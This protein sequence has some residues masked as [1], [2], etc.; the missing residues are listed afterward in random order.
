MHGPCS[1]SKL[2]FLLHTFLYESSIIYICLHTHTYIYTHIYAVTKTIQ[3][4]NPRSKY[5][6]A[7][8]FESTAGNRLNF[9][10]SE[11]QQCLYY[12]KIKYFER[13]NNCDS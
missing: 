9:C 13:S 11:M 10:N 12:I 1:S 5:T 6:V 4:Q 2:I 7:V 8:F 3:P